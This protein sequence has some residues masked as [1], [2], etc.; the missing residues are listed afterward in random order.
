MKVCALSDMHGLLEGLDFTGCDVA[1]IAGDSAP[2][3]SYGMRQVYKQ[4]KW[5]QKR[6]CGLA[7][8][9]PSVEFVVVPGNH[10]FF[11]V[12]RDRFGDRLDWSIDWPSNMRMLVDREVVVKGL[13]IYGSPWVP[14]ISR[15]WAFEADGDALKEKFS[16]IPEGLDFLVTH[17]PPRIPAYNFDYSLHPFVRGPFGSRE[18]A[19]EI[20]KKKPRHCVFGHIHTGEHGIVE[21]EGVK[22]ANVSL[23]DESYEMRFKPTMFEV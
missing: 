7:A 17:S 20:F 11:P 13:R 12:A 8:A 19:E 16:K 15:S 5:V 22:L 14:I 10:D 9:N 23:L 3:N 2:I 18:L 21:W 6:L 4:K 1:L